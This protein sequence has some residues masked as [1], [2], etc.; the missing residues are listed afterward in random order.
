MQNERARRFHFQC[1]MF[2]FTTE[3]FV[4]KKEYSYLLEL[5]TT[6][7]EIKRNLE[8]K[9]LF[10]YLIKSYIREHFFGEMTWQ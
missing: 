7:S 2:D 10:F 8:T 3:T 4:F 6:V 9:I 1:L 5:T